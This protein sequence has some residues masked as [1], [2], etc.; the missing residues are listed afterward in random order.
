MFALGNDCTLKSR[1]FSGDETGRKE[2][3]TCCCEEY[4]CKKS[5]LEGSTSCMRDT[6]D[7]SQ[8]IMEAERGK[9]RIA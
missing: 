2:T 4:W 1:L 9:I 6:G 7:I 8:K 3:E 5:R